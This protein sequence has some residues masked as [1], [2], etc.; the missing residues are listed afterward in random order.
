[1]DAAGAGIIDVGAAVGIIVVGNVVDTSPTVGESLDVGGG[2]TLVMR[3][4]LEVV[5]ERKI[6]EEIAGGM[7]RR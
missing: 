1:V 3:R 6:A 7:E 5:D 4:I 2:G